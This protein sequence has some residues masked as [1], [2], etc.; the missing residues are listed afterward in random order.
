[1]AP[2]SGRVVPTPFFP[3]GKINKFLVGY[4]T[5]NLPV[6]ENK[7]LLIARGRIVSINSAWR[8]VG[9]KKALGF[10]YRK[11]IDMN[12]TSRLF[13]PFAF[14]ILAL[15]L[16]L[17]SPV[18]GQPRPVITK[19][20][21]IHN[22]GRVAKGKNLTWEVT[23][24]NMGNQMLL[25]RKVQ[26][27][28]GA[29]SP[30]TLSR[31]T[32]PPRTSA[33][34]S[35]RYNSGVK[36]GKQTREYFIQTNSGSSSPTLNIV[37]TWD[38]AELLEAKPDAI[39]FGEKPFG[40]PFDA[41]LTLATDMVKTTVTLRKVVSSSPHL[42]AGVARLDA[43]GTRYTV[44]VRV[45]ASA[46]IGTFSAQITFETNYAKDPRVVIPISGIVTGPLTTSRSYI[47]FGIVPQGKTIEREVLISLAVGE[48]LELK[49]LVYDKSALECRLRK[50]D[51]G[52]FLLSAAFTAKAAKGAHR[53]SVRIQTNCPA[54][55]QIDLPV[56]A[57]IR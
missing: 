6:V 39:Q 26:K 49:N 56:I 57:M 20:E 47:N 10:A 32:I 21:L 23:L 40:K 51:N 30:L 17:D 19:G 45:L 22:F 27:G 8:M 15:V 52:D 35:V 14:L 24:S 43:S 42:Q 33:K 31:S 29:C 50:R 9:R 41:D 48:E 11:G 2:M 55:P 25:L 38:V 18:L 1:M 46:P 28:C 3:T 54:Q 44:P 12:N 36:T 4:E 7:H 53:S 5:A 34:I 37:L 16:C 13:A